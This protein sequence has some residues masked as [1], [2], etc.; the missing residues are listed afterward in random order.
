M[1]GLL[2]SL[3]VVMWFAGAF[4]PQ[5][6]AQGRNAV[7]GLITRAGKPLSSTWVIVSQAGKERGR[8]LTG[9]DGKFYIANLP[10]GAFDIVAVK[11]NKQVFKGKLA[12]PKDA[13]FN[14][15]I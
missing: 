15:K 3:A 7:K 5:A 11:D 1:K 6:D 8:S 10:D 12:L 4:A 14:I 2:L 13:S 9:D